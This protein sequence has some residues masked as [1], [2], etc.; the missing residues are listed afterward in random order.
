MVLTRQNVSVLKE[1]L[2]LMKAS[3]LR[4]SIVTSQ[5]VR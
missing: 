2:L 1:T 4:H 5:S 3:C